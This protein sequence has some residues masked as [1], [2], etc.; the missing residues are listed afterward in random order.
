MENSVQEEIMK[1]IQDQQ[2][3]AGIELIRG[4]STIAQR[5]TI[6]V[7]RTTTHEPHDE[8]LLMMK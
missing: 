5:Q 6:Q 8:L 3:G 1:I 4:T 2:N 7:E